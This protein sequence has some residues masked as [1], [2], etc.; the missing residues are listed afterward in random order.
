MKI[1]NPLKLYKWKFFIFII[2]MLRAKDYEAYVDNID[3]VKEKA[4]MTK[5]KKYEPTID[6]YFKIRDEILEFIKAK[7]RIIYGGYAQDQLLKVKD[8]KDGIYKEYDTPD[9]EFYTPTPV[10]DMQELCE[11]LFGKKYKHVKGGEGVHNETYKVFVNF[12]NYCDI[13]YLPDNIYEF[14]PTI[15]VNGLDMIHPHFAL[16]DTYRVYTDMLFSNFRLDKTVC[17]WQKILKHYNT[18]VNKEDVSKFRSKKDHDDVLEFIR[19][20]IIQD[21]DLVVVGDYC[22]N[23]YIKKTKYEKQQV[24]ENFYE[25]ISTNYNKEAQ[26]I[27]RRVKGL[28]KD[29]ITI[30]EYYPFFQF[31]GKRTLIL[32]KG[33]I[34]LVIYH[35]NFRCIPYKESVN[36]KCKFGTYQLICMYTLIN[37]IYCKIS[38][39]K[40]SELYLIMLS[41]LEKG[42]N[43]YID[44]HKISIMD[45]S[46]FEHFTVN[47]LGKG[48]DTIRQSFLKG[49]KNIE[50]KRRPKLTYI[51]MGRE[52][53]KITVRFDNSSGQLIK[54]PK[55]K[56]YL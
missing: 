42:K 38:C 19:H 6:E 9:V 41:N 50:R 36:K 53:P 16:I 11:V 43:Q 30:E 37:H 27:G 54:D 49:A 18:I 31:W 26:I 7:K 13:S 45:D 12:V 51:P 44:E 1:I 56:T 20:K 39:H 10:E 32:Y 46:P 34:V 25:V 8:K 3:D 23:Y 15:K 47:C 4:I 48:T 24:N 55:D 14:V 2:I 5:L 40:D 28:Y 17:R 33:H 21:S 29:D 22:Y 35:S 52:P